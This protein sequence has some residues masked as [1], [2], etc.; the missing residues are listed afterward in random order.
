MKKVF[1]I[2][3]ACLTVFIATLLIITNFIKIEESI[4]S[5]E[6][7][8]INIYKKSIAS[9][10]NKEYKNTDEEYNIILTKIQ[11]SGKTTLFERLINGYNFENN[12]EQVEGNQSSTSVS[13]IRKTNICVELIFDTKQDKIIYSGKN[14]KVV[15]YDK[16]M[17]VFVEN[18]NKISDVLVYFS[19]GSN[20]YANYNP[21]I[22]VGKSGE[23]I[24]YINN[25]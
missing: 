19:N 7:A 16:L 5:K 17:F 12:I 23:I 2:I 9:L 20:G 15:S 10:N 18:N 25:I 6:P 22:L 24:E 11:N 4:T 13:D 21:L 14:T 3:T 8:S 1:I